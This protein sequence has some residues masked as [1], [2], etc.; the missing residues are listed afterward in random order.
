MDECSSMESRWILGGCLLLLHVVT[1]FFGDFGCKCVF[2]F[3]FLELEIN[4]V[5]RGKMRWYRGK[6]R[7]MF[8]SY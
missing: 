8:G 6:T 3:F 4:G 5:E 7:K 1:V 2:S